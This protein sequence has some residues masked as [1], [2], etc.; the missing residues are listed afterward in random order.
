MPDSVKKSTPAE[1]SAAEFDLN[2]LKQSRAALR[3]SVTTMKAK[4]ERDEGIDSTILECRLQILESYFKQLSHIQTQIERVNEHD[5][6]RSDIEESYVGT[7]TLILTRLKAMREESTFD[8]TLSTQ[9]RVEPHFSHRLP[10]LK[11]PQFDGKYS[12]YKRFIST[13]TNLIDKESIPKIDKF[14]YL[15]NCLSGQA[16]A[17]IEAFQVT[18]LNYPK[19][20]ARLAERFD[21][22]VLIL[23]DHISSIF[24]LPSL[25]KAEAVHLRKYIDNVSALRS[26]MFSLGSC[27]E[28]L[29]A[30]IIHLVVSK[31]DSESQNKYNESQ[32]FK[33]VPT[34]KKC[35]ST[36]NRRC[37]FLE[38]KIKPADIVV[39]TPQ[40][41]RKGNTSNRS[42]FVNTNTTPCCTYCN[43]AEHSISSC[44]NFLSLSAK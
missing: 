12:E 7:K 9:G 17:A 6:T 32:D 36:L 19:A 30:M 39:K 23:K 25:S 21:N 35:Y 31:L 1:E 20:L 33:E 22:K 28:I 13:F 24:D 14:N 44:S 2:A 43:S 27:E 38:N 11:L 40:P 10:N 42:T 26:S 34:W 8:V 4:I 3:R 5:S 15:L 41:Q 16:L 18:E 37:Q 29:D